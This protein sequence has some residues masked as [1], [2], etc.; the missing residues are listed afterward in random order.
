[1]ILHGNV[2]LHLNNDIKGRL[3]LIRAFLFSKAICFTDAEIRL[4]TKE[5]YC[6]DKDCPLYVP[7]GFHKAG[8]PRCKYEN[9]Y[10]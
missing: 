4:T 7:A 3:L 1:M 2:T 9:T 6:N 10:R 8:M 5:E